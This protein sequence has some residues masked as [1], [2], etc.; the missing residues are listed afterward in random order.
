MTVK[1]SRAVRADFLG[2]TGFAGDA[3]AFD[4]CFFTAA[5]GNDLFKQPDKG[6]ICFRVNRTAHFGALFFFVNR[7]VGVA[8]CL[9]NLRFQS[10]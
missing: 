10:P 4:L 1:V 6:F 8:D 7:A 3:V 9:D 5:R 2:R